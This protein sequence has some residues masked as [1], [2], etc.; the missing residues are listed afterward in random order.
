MWRGRKEGGGEVE[1][2]GGRDRRRESQ[3]FCFAKANINLSA[4]QIATPS[5]GRD[6]HGDWWHPLWVSISLN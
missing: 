4:K 5:G 3:A 6:W 1:G 2:G